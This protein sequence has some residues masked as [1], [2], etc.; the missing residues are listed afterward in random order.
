V[1]PANLMLL[2]EEGRPLGVKLVDFGFAH[3]NGSAVQTPPGTALG[4]VAYMAPE[5]ILGD[6]VDGA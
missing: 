2:G 1:K 3:V 5:Q 6:R 4:T